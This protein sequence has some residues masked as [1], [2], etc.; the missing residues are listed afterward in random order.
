M[1]PSI[2]RRTRHMCGHLVHSS[3]HVSAMPTAVSGVKT[4]IVTL[5]ALHDLSA[6]KSTHACAPSIDKKH[7]HPDSH[8]LFVL[9]NESATKHQDRS[10]CNPS[11]SVRTIAPSGS[12]F[13]LRGSGIS[14]V[15][16]TGRNYEVHHLSRQLIPW[17]NEAI[18]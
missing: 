10:T 15:A 6:N 5:R 8:S 1:N 2:R 14:P 17:Q 11:L 7:T 16:E 9:A 4:D 3:Q 12:T 18:L 13:C